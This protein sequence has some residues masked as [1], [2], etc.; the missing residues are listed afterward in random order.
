M[1]S[2]TMV[3]WDIFQTLVVERRVLMSVGIKKRI[4]AFC[5]ICG[6]IGEAAKAKNLSSGRIYPC[7]VWKFA[8]VTMGDMPCTSGMKGL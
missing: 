1:V 2:F 5:D 7:S 3:E 4:F 6:E 8:D